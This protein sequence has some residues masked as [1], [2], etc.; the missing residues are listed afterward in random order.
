MSGKRFSIDPVYLNDMTI[1]RKNIITITDENVG[2]FVFVLGSDTSH[3]KESR[4]AVHSVQKYYPKYKLI[5]YDLGL[6]G[7]ENIEVYNDQDTNSFCCSW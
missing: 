4:G 5:Y 1:I 3:F 6:S 7:N 2:E